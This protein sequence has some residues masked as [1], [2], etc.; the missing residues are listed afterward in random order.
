[1]SESRLL[2]M[3]LASGFGPSFRITVVMGTPR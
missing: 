2:S 1:M 3:N